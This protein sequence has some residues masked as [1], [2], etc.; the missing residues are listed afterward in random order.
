MVLPNF[1]GICKMVR[2]HSTIKLRGFTS[3]RRGHLLMVTWLI[4]VGLYVAGLLAYFP[5]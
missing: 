1:I 4:S 3:I 2:F 5:H